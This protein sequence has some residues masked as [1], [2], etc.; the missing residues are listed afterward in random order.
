MRAM[1]VQ[2]YRLQPVPGARAQA[3]REAERL[4]AAR[5]AQP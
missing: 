2:K 3:K 1:A 5:M 4:L